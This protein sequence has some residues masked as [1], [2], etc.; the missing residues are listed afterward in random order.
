MPM[1]TT[2]STAF[3][4][5][6]DLVLSVVLGRQPYVLRLRIDGDRDI[7]Y[8]DL[9]CESGLN[10]AGATCHNC[11]YSGWSARRCAKCAA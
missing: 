5:M 6:T 4:V 9:S 2:A 10:N 11:Q 8:P 1:N 3:V 7:D